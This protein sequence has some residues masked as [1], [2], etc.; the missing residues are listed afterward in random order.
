MADRSL[1]VRG[2]VTDDDERLLLVRDR[3]ATW[4]HIPGGGLRHNETLQCGLRRELYEELGAKVTILDV[5][6]VWECVEKSSGDI[7]LS[8]WFDCNLQ[9][10]LPESW[11][12]TDDN[13]EE[14]KFFTRDDLQNLTINPRAVQDF[15]EVPNYIYEEYDV[16]PW[17]I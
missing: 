4:W 13:V 16:F 6:S 1:R 7:Y 17:R 2:V 11:S 12:D 3:G 15:P 14:S 10:T 9:D 8:I 5:R